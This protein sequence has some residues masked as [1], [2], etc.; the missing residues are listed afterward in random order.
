MSYQRPLPASEYL[1]SHPRKNDVCFSFPDGRQLPAS[2][3]LLSVASINFHNMF[4]SD[5]REEQVGE[6]VIRQ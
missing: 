5:W 6:M 2:K 3:F 1:S 4:S